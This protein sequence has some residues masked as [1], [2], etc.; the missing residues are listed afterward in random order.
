MDCRDGDGMTA[1]HYL[2]VFNGFMHRTLEVIIKYGADI[3]QTAFNGATALHLA[4]FNGT[5]IRAMA[6][7]LFSIA[8]DLD[9]VEDDDGYTVQ[10]LL[11]AE[12]TQMRPS[13]WVDRWSGLFAR[14]ATRWE[15][16]KIEVKS[17]LRA[18]A[19]QEGNLRIQN[20]GP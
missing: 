1:L 13:E 16:T 14:N 17:R 10:D 18:R 15:Q 5:N 11:S 19:L 20:T 12:D 4:F 3:R 9:L 8:P 2:I 6:L 7:T